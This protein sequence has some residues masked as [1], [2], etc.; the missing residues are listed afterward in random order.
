ME[1]KRILLILGIAMCTIFIIKICTSLMFENAI[2][3]D[4]GS[5]LN[6]SVKSVDDEKNKA[7]DDKSKEI[8]EKSKE[9]EKS[10][11]KRS[12][13]K[14]KSGD[15]KNKASEENLN[16]KPVE[17]KAK[18]S[19]EGSA[20]KKAKLSN[21]NSVEK[22][23]NDKNINS[24]VNEKQ[25]TK[26]NANNTDPAKFE[27]TVN[28]K[29][30]KRNRRNKK[31]QNDLIKIQNGSDLLEDSDKLNENEDDTLTA[32]QKEAVEIWFRNKQ[33]SALKP[34]LPPKPQNLRPSSV[35][36]LPENSAKMDFL[37][38]CLRPSSTGSTFSSFGHSQKSTRTT[39]ELSEIL[40][41][42]QEVAN[43]MFDVL[44]FEIH[45]FVKTFTRNPQNKINKVEDILKNASTRFYRRGTREFDILSLFVF[46]AR[47]D[48]NSLN[49][50]VRLQNI[51]KNLMMIYADKYLQILIIHDLKVYKKEPEIDSF[52]GSTEEDH[53]DHDNSNHNDNCD[54]N[55][56]H[57][58]PQKFY[59]P[60]PISSPIDLDLLSENYEIFLSEFSTTLND[61]PED[62]V[63]LFQ[64]LL[65]FLNCFY[66]RLK[67]RLDKY[68]AR[69]L[70][71]I[72]KCM[73][74]HLKIAVNMPENERK[75][76]VGYG[77]N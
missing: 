29:K 38:S 5:D 46:I 36:F 25:Q 66:V 51:Y 72:F 32:S 71:K 41:Y 30:R 50:D 57:R 39:E 54:S 28:K 34:P 52:P 2:K 7:S 70:I 64:N 6:E 56:S 37:D 42:D 16:G 59:I 8:D 43:S 65:N 3:N 77:S 1:K 60:L 19:K 58:N 73:F 17:K 24:V 18:F 26:S 48:K 15:E 33:K 27:A 74:E 35:Y 68:D 47:I 21:E 22:K 10:F 49:G 44:D 62:N 23:V 4:E 61:I 13:N 20:A 31:K 69:D 14:R 67:P 40:K 75:K 45:D 53:N 12:R 11:K 55:T 76:L 9:S 63:A